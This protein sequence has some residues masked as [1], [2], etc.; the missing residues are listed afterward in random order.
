M[1]GNMNEGQRDDSEGDGG[2]PLSD[3]VGL[4]GARA[5]QDEINKRI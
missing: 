2:D 5:E 1:Q 4:S 3:L